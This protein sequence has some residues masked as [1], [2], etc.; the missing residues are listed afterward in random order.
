MS[1]FL[2]I[3]VGTNGARAGVFDAAGGLSGSGSEA[4]P[5][6]QAE[7]GLAEYESAAI[8]DA[9]CAAVRKAMASAAARPD[10][11]AGI[12][13]DATCSMVVT[14]G[15]GGPVSVNP[16][17]LEGRDSIAWLDHRAVAEAEAINASGAA[18]LQAVGGRISPEMQ[19][20]KIA[21][22]AKHRP[23]VL[24]GAGGFFDLPDWLV[25]RA[26]GADVR[27]LCSLACKWTYNGNGSGWDRAFFE[28]LGLGELMA[29]GGKRLG[30][31]VRPPGA[32]AGSVT[33]R[34]AGELGLSDGTPVAVSLIDAHAGA[35]GTL[36]VAGASQT[37]MALIAGTSACHI[38]QTKRAQPV[39]GV[40]GPYA[41]VVLPGQWTLE[42]GQS[43]CGALLDVIIARHA[44]SAA[45]MQAGDVHDQLAELL[46]QMAGD[47]PISQLTATR[48][49]VPDVLGNRS[50][51]VDPTRQGAIWGLG[52]ESGPEDLARDYLAAIQ[53][54]A[55]G[56]RHI[57]DQMRAQGVEVD[58]IVV[59]GGLIHNPL[60]LAETATTTG[61]TLLV[62]ATPEPV[63][64]GSAMLG[65][66]ANG[67]HPTLQ[68]AMEAMGGALAT[69]I[70]PDAAGRAYAAA[71]YA[72]FRRMLDD[73]T[74][75]SALMNFEETDG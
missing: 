64:I 58:T 10:H 1:L 13:F 42:A 51:L 43:A 2:G 56:T 45:L 47:G 18:V 52:L 29:N 46:K 63:L 35:L 24:S 7:G 57:L 31:D 16:T 19:V 50:P 66:V 15:E 23:D 59:S 20:P 55:C 75:Y 8:W 71:K 49:V 73:H 14:P 36:G 9:V 39:P 53:A 21:W 34:A 68:T 33:V 54:L 32:R 22:L 5:L 3:D 6:H 12:G 65:S 60:F 62:P 37:V 28:G 40:W 48:H 30:T 27:S 72:V 61:C 11:I 25:Y 70:T 69:R 17:G 26:T 38:V 67:T 41:D 44:A 4:F 74:D